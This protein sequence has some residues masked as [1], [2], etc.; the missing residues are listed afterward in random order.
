[1]K[2]KVKPQDLQMGMYVA[3]LDRPWLESPFL[4]QGFHIT[5]EEEL[6]EL[7]SLCEFVYVDMDIPAA[8]Q[9]PVP[10]DSAHGPV[11]NRLTTPPPTSAPAAYTTRIEDEF[12]VAKDL[13]TKA[14]ASVSHLF[15]QLR[16]GE[17][18]HSEEVKSV[19]TEMLDSVMRN[20]DAM[21]LLSNLKAHD[22]MAESHSINVCIL[23][24]TFGRFL[25]L[26]KEHLREL[27]VAAM[28]HD[29]GETRIPLEIL[30]KSAPL[31]PS[32]RAIKEKHPEYGAEILRKM[33]GIP[34]SA[35]DVAYM[36]H[37]RIDGSG[38]PRRLKGDQISY[39]AKLVA[40]T[41]V[42]DTLTSPRRG[43]KRM[44]STDALKY[45]YGY[46]EMFFDGPLL[47][48]FIECLGIYPVGSVVELV[49]G[50]VG[51]VVSIPQDHRL[52]PRVMLVR[53]RDKQALY[54]PVFVN[55]AQTSGGKNV[56]KR[57]LESDAYGINL[58]DFILRELAF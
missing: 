31:K 41:N 15:G 43:E 45:M 51:V 48:R 54:P 58:K 47:E 1:M 38:Y 24:L 7:R 29:I 25:G 21:L 17:P 28:L 53:D 5:N 49:T 27:G 3:E 18:K 22:E 30:N 39:F 44:S 32:E 6:A 2:Q 13:H 55:L 16:H 50:E 8:T 52:L 46:R 14:K 57:V 10:R 34:D 19:V 42:Y 12:S 40:I 35:V 11:V 56:V 26:G 37:E 20:P 33:K 23:S 4:F 9:A 36:H